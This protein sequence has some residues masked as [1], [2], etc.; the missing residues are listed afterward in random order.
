P[1]G[2]VADKGT[3]RAAIDFPA[4]TGR[5]IMVKWTPAV[6][7]DSTPFAIAEIAAFSAGAD[8]KGLIAANISATM[9]YESDGKDAKDLGAG[10]DAKGMPEK[11]PPQE[12]PPPGLPH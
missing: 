2:S 3:G 6:Q 5:Y 1:V 4:A 9:A 12:G 11:G 8:S 10:K 7:H